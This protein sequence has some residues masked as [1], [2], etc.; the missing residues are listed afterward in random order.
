MKYLN[1]FNEHILLEG[2]KKDKEKSKKKSKDSEESK[3]DFK[4]IKK[5]CKKFG[6]KDFT[7]LENGSVDVNGDVLFD[8]NIKGMKFEKLPIKFNIVNGDFSLF[9]YTLEN[10]E[11]LPT[12]VG[13]DFYLYDTKIK[14]K[15]LVGCPIEVLGDFRLTNMELTSLEGSPEFVGIDYQIQ[16]VSVPN[17]KGI[18]QRIGRNYL[19][20]NC[21]SLK[22]LEGLPDQIPH[23]LMI[24]C[25]NLTSL[26]GC[27]KHIEE[28]FDCSE[29]ELKDL[30]G[31]PLNVLG[32]YD[33]SLNALT[34]LEGAPTLFQADF[35][36]YENY[37]TNLVG[38]PDRVNDLI[39]SQNLF[40]S[41]EGFP[42]H[43]E[44]D[45]QFYHCED[46]YSPEGIRDVEVDG[47]FTIHGS[48]LAEIVYLFGEEEGPQSFKN[49]Q[50]SLDY[51]YIRCVDD[52]WQILA[53]KLKE[54]L[55][56]FGLPYP[57]GHSSN[58]EYVDED[59]DV[60]TYFPYRKNSSTEND[61][62]D[63]EDEEYDENY[64]E[65]ENDFDDLGYPI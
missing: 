13:G 24:S 9:R 5:L 58:Y 27:P 47:D 38:A 61:D 41:L 18:S 21:R 31:G 34:S 63:D 26:S 42:K 23:C 1:N 2:K 22:N 54:A 7:I 12:H 14:T 35:I 15:N 3:I 56:E 64:D 28:D 8:S 39:A 62:E 19:I 44:G 40:T 29:N 50:E 46:L 16:G 11:G 4:E 52:E 60:L 36:C 17:F 59:G 37:L 6:L 45:A 33:C 10:L 32:S 43:V 57:K 25:C 51:N 65:E 49:F 20:Q 55:D 53:Y 30:T 48:P